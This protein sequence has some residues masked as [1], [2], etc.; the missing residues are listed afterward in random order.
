M[1]RTRNW[2]ER[3]SNSTFARDRPLLEPLLLEWL[4]QDEARVV[5]AEELP[6]R[7]VQL[8]DAA[9]CV[10]DQEGVAHGREDGVQLQTASLVVQALDGDARLHG[11]GGEAQDIRIFIGLGSIAL[12][13][14]HTEYPTLGQDR[15]HDARLGCDGLPRLG[16]VEEADRRSLGGPSTD[17]PRRPGSNHLARETLAQRKGT[18]GVLDAAVHLADDLHGRIRLVVEGE[19]KDRRIHYSRGLVMENAEE[20]CEVAGVVAER[21]EPTRVLELHARLPLTDITTYIAH[22]RRGRHGNGPFPA[23]RY[24]S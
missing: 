10:D 17:Q 2:P 20:L 1:L 19:E 9:P 18:A 23:R 8:H 13:G 14:K 7:P 3:S 22:S 5:Q 12:R 6:G 4:A 16:P 21:C 24:V 11:D 15:D